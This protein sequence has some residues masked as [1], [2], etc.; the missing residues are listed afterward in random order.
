MLGLPDKAYGEVVCAIV[1][2][3]ADLKQKRE[4]ESKPALTLQE[5]CDW[6][7]EKLAPYKVLPAFSCL[8]IIL[9]AVMVLF[10]IIH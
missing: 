7:K 3:D 8:V 6:A 2:P 4:A 1:V 9:E 5:L 10:I